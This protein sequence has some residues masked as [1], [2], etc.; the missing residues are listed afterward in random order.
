MAPEIFTTAVGMTVWAWGYS[1]VLAATNPWA[2]FPSPSNTTIKT[3]RCL[4]VFASGTLWVHRYSSSQVY[5]SSSFAINLVHEALAHTSLSERDR[6]LLFLLCI[7]LVSPFP[8]SFWV[9][10][11][12]L[13]LTSSPR[14]R[15]HHFTDVKCLLLLRILSI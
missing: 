11:S 5:T 13:G 8:P 4:E 6:A 14:L 12:S 9:S 2:L 15:N 1:R 7:L 10:S 3:K